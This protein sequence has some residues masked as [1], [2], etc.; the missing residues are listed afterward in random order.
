MKCLIIAAGKGSRLQLRGESKPLIPILGIPLIERVIRAAIEAG[1]DEF[2]VVVGFQGEQLS[3]YLARLADSLAI[4]ITPLVNDDWDQQ[5]GLSVLKAR[6]V[7]HEPF[8]LLMAD[9]L[10]DPQLV[11]ELTSL[12]LG[13]GE[14]ALVVDGNTRNP[15]IDMEDVTR[16]K[17]EDDVFLQ[18]CKKS[19][20]NK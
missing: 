9:H 5:N 3:H 8:L 20:K 14:I 7:L 2:I 15:L 13:D 19:N 18:S 16:V 10:F 12:E 11:R 4:Q 6:E 17:L 1:A